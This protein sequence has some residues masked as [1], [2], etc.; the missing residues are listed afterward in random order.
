MGFQACGCLAH[1][2]GIKLNDDNARNWLQS[3]LLAT[4]ATLQ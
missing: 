3:R 1:A 2:M 4:I